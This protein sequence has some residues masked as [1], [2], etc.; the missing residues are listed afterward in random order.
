LPVSEVENLLLLPSVF[1]ALAKTLKFSKTEAQ[2]KL[3]ALRTVVF[4]HASKQTDAICLRHA[5]R[6]IDL[7][8]KKIG[9]A[10]KDVSA[11]NEKFKSATTAIDPVAVFSEAK[12]T[13]TTIITAQEYEKVLSLYD[14]KG[15]LAEVAKLF[16]YQRKALEEFIG[17]ALRSEENPEI[18]TT[19]RGC[20]PTITARP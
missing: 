10:G 7:A 11:L 1:L 16:G 13:L 9:L 2:A 20:L 5:R 17:R 4:D 8:M 6:R 3:T 19:L 12:S 18:H 15:L 14:N